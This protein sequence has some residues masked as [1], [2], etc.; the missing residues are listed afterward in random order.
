MATSDEFSAV[1]L[2]EPERDPDLRGVA[3]ALTRALAAEEEEGEPVGEPSRGGAG[4]VIAL[5]VPEP[6]P[7]RL[8]EASVVIALDS[9]SA[10][11]AREAGVP[12]VV[13]VEPR[14]TLEADRTLDVDL[15][16]VAHEALVE[17]AARRG[18]SARASGPIAPD[19]WTK[20]SERAALAADLGL[21]AEVPWVVVRAAALE[22]DPAAALVQL[23]LVR[24]RCVWL[25]DVGGD[26]ELARR[27][28]RRVPGYALDALMFADGPESRRCYQAADAVLG[29]LHGPEMIRALAVGAAPVALPP[30]AEDVHVANALEHAGIVS[31]ADAAATLAVTLDAALGAGALTKAREAGAR[32]DAGSGARRA[33]ELVRKL[34]RGELEP[35]EVSGLP[36]GIE[37]LSQP[38][39]ERLPE[40]PERVDELDRSV[41]EELA[42]L[43]KKLGL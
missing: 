16:L 43:R 37:R 39:P 1:V 36:R 5:P 9:R 6:S 7:A 12:R 32:L 42:A 4:G 34:I 25:F 13:L 18:L 41:D 30:R 17:E 24:E 20:S 21:R 10:V 23:A 11:R 22:D 14:L 28:R 27:L 29:A 31:V 8:D 19:E 35:S 33:V 40:R 26:A 2:F 15:V 3:A 38:E